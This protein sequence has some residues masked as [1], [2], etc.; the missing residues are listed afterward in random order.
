MKYFKYLIGAMVVLP[1]ACA[2]DKPLAFD[3][4]KPALMASMEYLNDYQVLKE[5]KSNP[6]LK[7]GIGATASDYINQG[8]H[9]RL[10]N[11]NFDEMTAGNAMKYASCVSDD[12]TMNFSTVS[13]FVSAARD[14]GTT[15]YGH[16]LAWHSQ[17]NNKYLNSLLADREIEIDPDAANVVEDYSIKYADYNTFPFYNMG[18]TPTFEGSTMKI[19]ND[20][21][22]GSNWKAQYFCGDNISTPGSDYTVTIRIKGS[23]AGSLDIVMGDWST[24][25]SKEMTFTT[26]WQEQTVEFS[27]VSANT[28]HIIGQSGTFVGDIEMEWLKVTHK[29][30]MAVSWWTSMIS[31]GDAEGTEVTSA[32]STH[33]GGSNGACDIEDGAGK[34]GGRAYV[35]TS[36]GN[37]TNAWDTQFFLTADR[38]LA[39][40]DKVLV[41]FDYRATVANSA[42]SQ[43]HSTPGSYIYWDGGCSL[44]FT[45]EWQHFEKTMTINANQ[46]PSANMKTIAWNL[47]VGTSSA[48]ANKY[49]FD[50]IVFSIEE[51][52]NTIPLTAQEKKDTLVW[53]MD[54]WIK[55]MMEATDGYVTA[56]DAVNEPISGSDAD[57]DGYYDLWSSENGDP[58][59]NF[60]WQDYMG[61]E[62]YVRTVIAKAREY[63]T[64]MDQLKLFVNDYNLES[65]WDDNNKVKSLIHW[66]EVWESDGV[67]KIDGIGTQMHVSCYA[68]QATQSSKKEHVTK[69][70]ELLAKS[71]KLIK[72]SELDMSY[73]DADGNDVLTADMTEDQHKAMAEYYKFIIQQY[74]KIIPTAQQY[75]ITQWCIQD[76]P[77]GSGW[78]AGCPVGLWDSDYNRKHTYAGFAEGLKGE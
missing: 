49:Y 51:S 76:S 30:A 55:G 3:V 14:A 44:S 22:L 35:V 20:E 56:W 19:S 39:E 66:I 52:G 78:R 25:S 5:Y 21:D 2:D 77:T 43:T 47:D 16:C 48:P 17:Q 32:T 71:G 4:E 7:L 6:N 34:D 62:D 40:G 65:D 9:Y 12:G 50:N 26:E 42:E 57:G 59:S 67:T 38:E 69:M 31:N 70:F 54:R 41:S 72:I 68:D 75:G 15:I 23:S 28:S 18:F 33:I 46:S 37:A 58:S 74:L 53:A 11:D 61:D 13:S 24:N 45:S 64:G 27:G 60:Y 36:N 73:V 1:T 29:E 8:V 63:Y 10:V